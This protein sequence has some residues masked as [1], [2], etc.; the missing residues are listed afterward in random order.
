MKTLSED[1]VRRLFEATTADRLHG[2]WILLATT[3]LR[4]G[5]AIGLRWQDVDLGAQ[6]LTVRRALQRQREAGLVFVEPKTKTSRRSISLPDGTARALQGHRK[7]QLEERLQAGA[8]W[9]DNDLV[10]CRWDGEVIEPSGVAQRFDGLLRKAGLP[11]IRVHDLRHTAASLHLLK[12]THP[13]V[14]QE[15]LGHSTITL[16]L[17]T[18]SHVAPGMHAAAAKQMDSLFAAEPLTAVGAS[19]QP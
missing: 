4:L 15:M 10:F 12:G 16:T 14:V 1:Q 6:T 18:Y 3:G 13:K 11:D 5:E 2:L 17:D 19:N 9:Q 7:R 8:G